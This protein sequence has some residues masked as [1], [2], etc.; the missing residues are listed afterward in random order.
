MY[1]LMS[2]YSASFDLAV[3]NG[4][5]HYHYLFE[6]GCG[7]VLG[8]VLGLISR[9][10]P[11]K[12]SRRSY[13]LFTCIAFGVLIL[14]LFPGYNVNGVLYINGIR[15]ISGAYVAVFAA[16]MLISGTTASIRNLSERHGIFYG[17]VIIAI[18]GLAFLTSYT[19]GMASYFLLMLTIV[20]MM[21]ASGVNKGY[22]VITFI[23]LLVSGIF[24]ISIDKNIL[25][26]FFYSI[27][28]VSDYSLY[29]HDL[30][31][32]HM[33]IKDGGLW[34]IGIGHG[35]Y[36]LGLLDGIENAFI[37]SSIAEETGLVGVI[38]LFLLLI[39]YMFLGIRASQRAVK[40]YSYSIAG[41][42]IGISMFIF[43]SA[44]INALYACG[45]FPFSGA[46]FP[47]F[48]FGPGE[49]ALFVFVSVIQYRFIHLMG[50]PNDKA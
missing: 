47:F 22:S 32:S 20:S 18:C 42:S 28:P 3:R 39:S 37:F 10:L 35:L 1:G 4:Y 50:R 17:M 23:F 48:S 45:L 25:S 36:K 7:A 12:A 30:L 33:A 26:D 31:I 15:I 38:V 41:A 40:K 8:L 16:I 6:Q 9:I 19:S 14:M 11:I 24:L 49:E 13:Y 2:L 5:V 21:H 29:D 34:G 46:V 44:A 43:F 27:M